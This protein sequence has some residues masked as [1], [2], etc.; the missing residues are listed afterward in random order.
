MPSLD[1]YQHLFSF[2]ESYA[3]LGE[4]E[5]AAFFAGEVACVNSA[6]AAALSLGTPPPSPYV[7]SV[8]ATPTAHV[9]NLSVSG[10]LNGT[11]ELHAGCYCCLDL[12]QVATQLVPMS[13]VATSVITH[14]ISLYPHREEAMC[15][16]GG[17]AMAKDLGPF[18]GYGH[19]VAPE[20]AKGWELGR[21]SQE[22]GTL[23]RAKGEVGEKVRELELGELLRVVG[24]HSCM[25][26]AAYPWYYV[27]EDGG[28]TVV[29]VWVPWKGW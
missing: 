7:L 2:S 14:V 6:A 28:D 24:Q 22:H 25:T 15:D 3:S 17:I 29:D 26:L 12:Q 19:V 18:P 21:L 9:A 11:L 27:V 23:V 8:G 10:S 1:L 20:S 4:A 16:A 5:A 13:R